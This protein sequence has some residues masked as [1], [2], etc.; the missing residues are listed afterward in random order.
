[1]ISEIINA[2]KASNGGEN[3]LQFTMNINCSLGK[4]G[5]C[6]EM[7]HNKESLNKIW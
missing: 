5:E 4:C 2:D 6:P 3:A 1:M 7:P